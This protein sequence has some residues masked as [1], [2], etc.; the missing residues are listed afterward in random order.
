MFLSTTAALQAA[1]DK[2]FTVV[3]HNDYTFGLLA[4]RNFYNECFL[5]S[6]VSLLHCMVTGDIVHVQHS[7]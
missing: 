2:P 7:H 4:F 5:L 3:F 1:V 6:I